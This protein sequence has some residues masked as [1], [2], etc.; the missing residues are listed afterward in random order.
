MGQKIRAFFQETRQ[1][2][3]R[4]DWPSREETIRYTVF[5]VIFSAAFAIFLGILDYGF[6]YALE[7]VVLG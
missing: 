2:L 6:M 3:K 1:E 7:Q 4:V 5:V